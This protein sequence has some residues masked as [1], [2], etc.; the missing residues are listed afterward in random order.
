[1]NIINNANQKGEKINYEDLGA[2]VMARV[3]D[4]L[5]ENTLGAAKLSGLKKIVLAGG[6]AANSVL[7]N[8]ITKMCSENNFELFIPPLSLCGDNAAMIGSQGFYEFLAGKKADL[9]LN[10][11][12]T[13]DIDF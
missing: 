9:N 1:M 3:A 7:R 4:C 13:M 6:V 8:K 11:F 5:V 12:A 2:S 10:A